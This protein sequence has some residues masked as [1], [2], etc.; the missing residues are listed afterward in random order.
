MIQLVDLRIISQ[1]P[2]CSDALKGFVDMM[3]DRII[4]YHLATDI[5]AT[6]FFF[7]V[8]CEKNIS[9]CK[10]YFTLITWS[11]GCVVRCSQ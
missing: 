5:Y 9:K 7:M 2:L 10:V 4:T 8:W 1:I 3:S 11:E 6:N